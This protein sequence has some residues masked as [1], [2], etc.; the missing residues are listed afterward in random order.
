VI[1]GQSMRFAC[2]VALALGASAPG[3]DLDALVKRVKAVGAE[4]AGNADAAAAWKE[5]SRLD[6]SAVVP[7]L[8][9]FDGASGVAG[10][11]LRSA[12]DAV[13]ERARAAKTPLPADALKALLADRTRDPRAR[14]IA[15]E[16]LLA[17]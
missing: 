14:R 15:Y 17:A 5:L 6:A 7:L 2:L 13:T 4:G 9:A 10:N 12:L 1:G 8:K 11:Y 3:A 16:L